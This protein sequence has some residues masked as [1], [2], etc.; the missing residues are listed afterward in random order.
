MPLRPT[1][2]GTPRLY[3]EPAADSAGTLLVRVSAPV[4]GRGSRGITDIAAYVRAL[5][6]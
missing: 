2:P 5:L 3:A 1:M 4:L 6:G